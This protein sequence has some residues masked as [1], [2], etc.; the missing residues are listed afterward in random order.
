MRARSAGPC[1][2]GLLLG[3][4][5]AQGAP[6]GAVSAQE[7]V[8]RSARNELDPAN[9]KVKFMLRDQK[10]TASGS[11]TKVFVQTHEAVAGLVVAYNDQPLNPEQQRGE[12]WRVKRFLKDP[13]EMKKKQKQEKEDGERYER[14]IK[15][16]P[17]A[18][19]YEY[20]GTESARAGVGERG[21]ALTRLRFRPNPDYDPPTRVEQT[22]TGMEGHMLIDATKCRIARIEG[23]LAKDVNFGW[24][25][26]GHLDK[27]GHILIEQGDV[28]QGEWRVTRMDLAFTGK[29]LFFKSI[30]VQSSEVS[31]DF[32]P[33]PSDLTFAQGVEMLKQQQAV[34]AE[35]LRKAAD[36][37]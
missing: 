5:L 6:A 3:T 37:K 33:V 20:D 22:L 11:Q 28:W 14:I 17:D 29:I 18:F 12:M 7:L 36:P 10:R 8:R 1:L 19:L 32:H 13:E 21:E 31:S 25:F 4:A 27:G 30:S 23:T 26:L 16:L 9:A 2:V 35:N 15:A 34:I 24:G